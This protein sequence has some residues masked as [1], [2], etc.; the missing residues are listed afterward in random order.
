MTGFTITA[1][2]GPLS[3]SMRLMQ[4]A[5]GAAVAGY[6]VAD[7]EMVLVESGSVKVQ[8]R[9]GEVLPLTHDTPAPGPA[10]TTVLSGGHGVVAH[11]GAEIAYHATGQSPATILLVTLAPAEQAR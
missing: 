3:L 7:S 2:R 8:I 1:H 9:N 6:L 4:I 10:G 11:A 5:P